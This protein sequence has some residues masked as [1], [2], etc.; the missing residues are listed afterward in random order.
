MLFNRKYIKKGDFMSQINKTKEQ[1]AIQAANFLT[2]RPIWIW[3][4]SYTCL[5]GLL[6]GI[7]YFVWNILTDK[8]WAVALII[9]GVGIVWGTISYYNQKSSSKTLPSNE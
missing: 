6:F 3:W 5:A 8:W 1:L 2:G 4:I 7:F 9:L